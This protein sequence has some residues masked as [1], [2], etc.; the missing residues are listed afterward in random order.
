MLKRFFFV[1]ALLLLAPVSVF[2][3]TFDSGEIYTLGGSDVV[4]GN[5][6]IG[7]ANASIYGAVDGDLYL[8]GSSAVISGPV[9]DDLNLVASSAMLTGAVDGDAR[10]AAATLTLGSTI[11][12]ELMATGG[13]LQIMDG[14]HIL[15]DV[16]VA[17]GMVT[18]DGMVGGDLLV[19]GD[20]VYINGIIE[21]AAMIYANEIY[22]GPNAMIPAGLGATVEPAVEGGALLGDIAMIDYAFEKPEFEAPQVDLG[23]LK[24]FFAMFVTIKTLS[25]LLL[26]MLLVLLLPKFSKEIVTSVAGREFGWSLLRGF[27]IGI[28]APVIILIGFISMIGTSVSLLLIVVQVLFT[29]LAAAL[30]VVVLGAW[31]FW[32]FNKNRKTAKWRVDWLSTLVGVIALML[33]N[34]IPVLGWLLCLLIVLATMGA[35]W[36]MAYKYIWLKRKK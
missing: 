32:I 10:I 25:I 19:S 1:L 2:A 3:A 5:L 12:G 35:L 8:A 9:T 14:A 21:G 23:G 26:A 28:I 15:G 20:V 7:S 36:F 34:F 17:G 4:E 24:A 22:I 29:I 27:L 30:A 16:Y 18:I 13:M 33:V 11:G 31:I 6:Y